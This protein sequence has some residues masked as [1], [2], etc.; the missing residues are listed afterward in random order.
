MPEGKTALMFGGVGLVLVALMVL[1]FS[2]AAYRARVAPNE[3]NRLRLGIVLASLAVMLAFVGGFLI[4]V[5]AAWG[6]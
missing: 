3:R 6:G 2:N 1:N 4:G 5:G